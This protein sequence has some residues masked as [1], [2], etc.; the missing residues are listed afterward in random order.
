VEGNK[1]R[2]VDLRGEPSKAKLYEAIKSPGNARGTGRAI[3]VRIE[4]ST[5]RQLIISSLN[6]LLST[7]YSCE[8]DNAG[9]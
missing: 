2:A 9:K 4:V 8:N 1:R 5:E 7:F 6:Q 3:S